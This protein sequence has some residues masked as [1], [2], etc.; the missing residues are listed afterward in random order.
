WVF[1]EDQG[2]DLG[3]MSS[4]IGAFFMTAGELVFLYNIDYTA[5]KVEIAGAEQWDGG[6]LEWS[7]PSPR[8]FYNFDQLLL[9][10]GLDAI[11]LVDMEGDGT[12]PADEPLQDVHMPNNS[13]LPFLMSLGFF[14]AG[15]GFIYQTDNSMWYLALYGGMAFAIGT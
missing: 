10:R 6:T 3:N 13:F 12:M 7:S 5:M 9:L 8:T 4:T 14:V 11:W 2:L 1:L 15:F